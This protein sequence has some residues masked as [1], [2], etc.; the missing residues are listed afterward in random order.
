MSI[1][2][3]HIVVHIIIINEQIFSKPLE[4]NNIM[5]YT[6]LSDLTTTGQA[7][8]IKVKVMRMWDSVNH[9]TD[10]LMSIDM[11]LMDEQVLFLTLIAYCFV[12][13]PNYKY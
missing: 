3:V 13:L 9:M 6:N 12:V 7:S 11:I 10:E 5:A 2:P 8:N 4:G 1:V